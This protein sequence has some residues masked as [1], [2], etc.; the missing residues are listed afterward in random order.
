MAN[1]N[2]PLRKDAGGSR[3]RYAGAAM[4]ASS[5]Q[6]PGWQ[7]LGPPLPTDVIWTCQSTSDIK[8][9]W[10]CMPCWYIN[11]LWGEE[12]LDEDPAML[13]VI[14][15]GCPVPSSPG[16][17]TVARGRRDPPAP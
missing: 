14:S 6:R 10:V 5:G 2:R 7:E 3:A 17:V 11:G 15:P 16:R 13:S 4:A 9:G 12:E 8:A 1:S